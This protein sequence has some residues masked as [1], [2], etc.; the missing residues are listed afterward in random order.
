[1]G[2]LREAGQ[3]IYCVLPAWYRS[4]YL[5]SG[6]TTNDNALRNATR[7]IGAT[8][9]EANNSASYFNTFAT[10]SASPLPP[11]HTLA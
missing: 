1:M 2:F 11:T 4:I 3:V 8:F 5:G 6:N 10:V 9:I 7:A